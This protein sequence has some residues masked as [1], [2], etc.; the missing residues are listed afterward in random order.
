MR[1]GTI[2]VMGDVRRSNFVVK[3]VDYSPRVKFVVGPVDCVEGALDEVVI[4]VGEMRY[5]CVSVLE[6]AVS[7]KKHCKKTR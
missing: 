3:E 7:R 4:I 2:E 6:P 5:I 1:D